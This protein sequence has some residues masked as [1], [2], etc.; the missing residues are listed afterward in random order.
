MLLSLLSRFFAAMSVADAVLSIPRRARHGNVRHWHRSAARWENVFFGLP[1]SA[2]ACN[3]RQYAAG[4]LDPCWFAESRWLRETLQRTV[5][6]ALRK[7][8]ALAS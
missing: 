7:L 8:M 4:S 1:V 5:I 3:V 6:E 2:L